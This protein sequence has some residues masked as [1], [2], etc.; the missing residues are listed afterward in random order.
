MRFLRNNFGKIDFGSIIILLIIGSCVADQVMEHNKEMAMIENGIKPPSKIEAKSTKSEI[1]SDIFVIKRSGDTHEF[2]F[3]EHPL[4]RE[5]YIVC[6]DGV[7]YITIG[8]SVWGGITQRFMWD[9]YDQK[10]KPIQCIDKPIK[11]EENEDP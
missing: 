1:T 5:M 8:T 9:S 7:E 3:T 4:Y 2:T 6:M 11:V 10:L